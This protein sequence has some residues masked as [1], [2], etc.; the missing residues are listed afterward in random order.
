MSKGSR[1]LKAPVSRRLNADKRGP[2]MTDVARLAGVSQM[3]VSRVMRKSGYLSE[4][5]MN[6]V[7]GAAGQ[8][9]Y[10][11]NRLAGGLAGADSSLV[12]VILP[13]LRNQVFTEVLSGIAGALG[14]SGIQPVFGVSEYSQQTETALVLDMLAWR[15]QG[16]ILSGLEHSEKLRS[17]L[18]SSS[19]RIAEIMDIDGAPIESCFGFSHRK[20]GRQMAVHLL[21]KG[22]RRFAYVGSQPNRDLRAQK[23]YKSF[24]AAIKRQGAELVAQR[25]TDE[26]STMLAGRECTELIMQGSSKPE[27]IYYANDDLAAGGLMHCL[28]RQIRVPE[29]LALAGFNGLNFL[30]SL[31]QRITTICTPRF[32][33]GTEAARFVSG[34]MATEHRSNKLDFGVILN[35]G[36]TS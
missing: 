23:R 34:Q 3:T 6:R 15:P 22:Y 29:Q 36:E 31:P 18:A 12:G 27:V 28:A 14:D 24:I 26:P 4:D 1:Q 21:E 25:I 10:V 20:A 32:E 33:I 11:H 9:G 17:T 16:L 8:L 30:E 19:V 5:V 13:D 2:T 7:H 35:P